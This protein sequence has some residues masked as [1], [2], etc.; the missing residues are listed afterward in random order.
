MGDSQEWRQHCSYKVF[1]HIWMLLPQSFLLSHHE[2]VQTGE[3]FAYNSLR[4]LMTPDVAKEL[5]KKIE[6]FGIEV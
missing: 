1:Q 2:A 5:N 6:I 3:Q 4:P